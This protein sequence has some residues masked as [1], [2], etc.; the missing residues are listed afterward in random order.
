M[1]RAGLVSRLEIVYAVIITPG[2]FSLCGLLVYVRVVVVVSVGSLQ[3]LRGNE[4]LIT[5]TGEVR[6]LNACNLS[7]GR[8]ECMRRGF[9]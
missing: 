8:V 3:A 2:T 4:R 1:V 6:G 7:G 9:L 5:F